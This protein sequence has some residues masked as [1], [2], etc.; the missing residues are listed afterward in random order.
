MDLG[1]IYSTD[2]G[3]KPILSRDSLLTRLA[4]DGAVGNTNCEGATLCDALNCYDSYPY[5]C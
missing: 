1:R 5:R 4:S 3:V 2:T